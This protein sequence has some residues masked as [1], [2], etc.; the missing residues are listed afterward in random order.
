MLGKKTI[1]QG[2]LI[3]FFDFS[4][5][6]RSFVDDFTKSFM[7]DH[8]QFRWPKGK[9][10]HSLEKIGTLFST[11]YTT[12]KTL[13]RAQLNKLYRKRAMELHPDQG[14]DHNLFIELTEI[15]QQLRQ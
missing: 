9:P 11:P 14:G 5:G 12:L 2:G 13:S 15:Y 6:Y 1:L 10:A 7:R 8:R 4:P 3:M